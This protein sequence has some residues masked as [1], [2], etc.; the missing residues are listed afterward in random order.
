MSLSPPQWTTDEFA[1][2]VARGIEIFREERLGEAREDYSSHFG[3]ALA[4]IEDV[5]ELSTDLRAVHKVGGRIVSNLLYLEAFRYVAAP[6]ISTED[7]ETLSG[8]RRGHFAEANLW[9]AIVDTVMDL[10]DAQRFPWVQDSREPTE[11]ERNSA[12]VATAALIASRRIMTARANESKTAQE[13]LVKAALIGAGFI[14]VDARAIAT[15][16]TAP[17]PGEFCGESLLG[18]RK[19]D[20]IVGLWDDRVLA[21]ECKVSNS[22]VNSIKR[23][24]NDAGGK[25][26]RWIGE[27]GTQLIVPA[28]VIA[29]VYKVGSLSSAQSVGLTI[30]WSHDIQRMVE[31]IDQTRGAR[32][33]SPR[34]R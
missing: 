26:A 33:S 4:A 14:E 18:S 20:I 12:M 19:A 21:I 8:I 5:L 15:L 16:R 23:V 10:I 29:G 11:E 1:S 9:P 34:R 3:E 2:G 25:A 17:S 30:W 32:R 27:F 24:K 13:E 28:A 31:W 7:L 6:P 22:A